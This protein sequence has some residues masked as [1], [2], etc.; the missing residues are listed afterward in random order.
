[1]G[2]LRQSGSDGVISSV[3]RVE[4]VTGVT[5]TATAL[6]EQIAGGV[7]HYGTGPGSDGPAPDPLP[8]G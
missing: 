7:G 2:V 1:V 8:R 3:D 6:A 5:V 4:T